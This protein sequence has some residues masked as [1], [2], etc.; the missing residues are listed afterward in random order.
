MD[1]TV[2][3]SMIRV[4]MTH[5]I[6]EDG[7]SPME[8]LA[9][10]LKQDCGCS[11]PKAAEIM[12]RMAGRTVSTSAVRSYMT[13]ARDKIAEKEETPEDDGSGEAAMAYRAEGRDRLS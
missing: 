10:A 13:K 3:D 2:W 11:T 4:A 12:S 6:L 8:A 9:F 7:L 1:E 5:R